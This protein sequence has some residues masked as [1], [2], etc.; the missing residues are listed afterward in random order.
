MME[1]IW[2]FIQTLGKGI[3][4][5]VKQFISNDFQDYVPLFIFAAIFIIATLFQ[6]IFKKNKKK[7]E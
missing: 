5:G 6:K 1:T 3:I 4:Q 2:T 7:I